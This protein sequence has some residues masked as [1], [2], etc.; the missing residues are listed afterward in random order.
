MFCFST[1]PIRWLFITTC[2][3]I[4]L[5]ACAGMRP[6]QTSTPLPAENQ[7]TTPAT[8]LP[9]TACPDEEIPDPQPSD[10]MEEDSDYQYDD[11][12]YIDR[13]EFE[14]SCSHPGQMKTVITGST[15]DA[16]TKI[17]QVE[18]IYD[19]SEQQF[20][21]EFTTRRKK[22]VMA[23]QVLTPFEE[24]IMIDIQGL[25]AGDYPVIAPYY[26]TTLTIK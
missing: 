23:A 24:T 5:G 11:R 6:H 13:I 2:L 1:R 12:V 21:I 3:G 15:P 20:R 14:L 19:D 4:L 9:P 25:P 18:V 7:P 16:A 22:D 10:E 17:H 8:D 26:E